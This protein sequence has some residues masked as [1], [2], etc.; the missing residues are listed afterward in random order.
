[1]LEEVTQVCL[2]LCK[3]NFLTARI[4]VRRML[5][6]FDLESV[7]ARPCNACEYTGQAT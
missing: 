2:L 1:M 6:L 4:L 7:H 5:S 3:L